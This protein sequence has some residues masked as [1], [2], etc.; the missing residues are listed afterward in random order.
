MFQCEIFHPL[1]VQKKPRFSRGHVYDPSKK[2]KERIQWQ[3]NQYKIPELL[4]EPCV[5]S[6]Q[7]FF[8]IPKSTSK[9]I[10][11]L[12]LSGLIRPDI[13][14]DLSNLAYL[15]EN[16]LT[17]IVYDDDKRRYVKASMKNSIQRN[18]RQ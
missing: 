2:D 12:M 3:I 9:K 14:P 15:V 13:R 10:R 4:K 18:Q 1:S 7:F 8:A 17:G 16:A 5:L 6:L 11:Q